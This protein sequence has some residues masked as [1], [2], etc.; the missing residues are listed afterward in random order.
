MVI[1]ANNGV[2]NVYSSGDGTYSC[3][4]LNI[5]GVTKEQILEAFQEK[6][7]EYKMFDGK[8]VLQTV[9]SNSARDLINHARLS[10]DVSNDRDSISGSVQFVVIALVAFLEDY[11]KSY[12][13]L[14][15]RDALT[16]SLI[17]IPE[18]CFKYVGDNAVSEPDQVKSTVKNSLSYI[19]ARIHSASGLNEISSWY[20]I[21]L[22]RKLSDDVRVDQ[23]DDIWKHIQA[24]TGLRNLFAHGH[25][26]EIGHELSEEKEMVIPKETKT[27]KQLYSVLESLGRTE[28]ILN[29]QGVP[30]LGQ[31]MEKDTAIHF[32]KKCSQALEQLSLTMHPD[33]RYSLI[34]QL[35]LIQKLP[36]TD[37]F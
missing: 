12:L 26:I 34:N 1:I 19:E 25:K 24:L 8:A 27:F 31:F 35:S 20:N 5:S 30:D 3:Y 15:L 7:G 23:N 18:K 22:N 9:S 29:D 11:I 10:L 14:Q 36:K 37:K 32:W 17:Y 21:L 2:Y 4:H 33:G 16:C 13:I 6:F 28:N